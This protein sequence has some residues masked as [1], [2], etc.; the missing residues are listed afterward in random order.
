V[1]CRDLW[2]DF[3][4]VARLMTLLPRRGYLVEEQGMTQLA[5]TDAESPLASLSGRC[6]A[7]A[8]WPG[9]TRSPGK[10]C[11]PM[12]HGFSLRAAARLA[13]VQR[14]GLERMCRYITRPALANE[15]PSRNA[16]GQVVWKLKS[17]RNSL[18]AHA[19]SC[20]R[21]S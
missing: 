8:R 12:P 7:C 6:S 14:K 11:A 15:R 19:G 16:N 3:V 4:L 21:N 1:H 20:C 10:R 18:S 17:R 9:G 5:D 13:S 2:S